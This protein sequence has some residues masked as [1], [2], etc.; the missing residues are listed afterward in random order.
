M[1]FAAIV[2]QLSKSPGAGGEGPHPPICNATHYVHIIHQW[3]C[4]VI[5]LLDIWCTY[6]CITLA[7]SLFRNLHDTCHGCVKVYAWRGG[8]AVDGMNKP[9]HV[10]DVHYAWLHWPS[11]ILVCNFQIAMSSCANPLQMYGRQDQWR[12]YTLYASSW[13]P[14]GTIKG[15]HT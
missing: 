10:H 7:R 9:A 15:A 11:T 12:Q 4:K 1:C 3:S 5:A 8:H 13:E 6:I 2:Y 14:V